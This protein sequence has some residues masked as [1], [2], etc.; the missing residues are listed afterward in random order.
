MEKMYDELRRAVLERLR[1]EAER[2]QRRDNLTVV[3][4]VSNLLPSRSIT[5][6]DQER[7]ESLVC[8]IYHEL[9]LE[10][11]IAPG[12]GN[13]SSTG[14]MEWPWYHITDHGK[15][16][17]QT[18]EYSP[19]DPDGYLRRLRSEIP[20]VE[21][22]IVRYVEESLKCLRM[23]C[24]LAAAVT[25]GC[26][27]E[28]AMLLLI[29]QFGKAIS[30]LM[31]R[32]KYEKETSFWTISSKYKTFRKNLDNVAKTLP[33]DLRDAL[34]PQLHGTFDLI[35]RIRNE[36]GH[37]TGE[38][39]TLETIR[40]SHIVFPGFCKYVYLLMDHFTRNGVNL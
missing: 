34:E 31:K 37:P 11:I 25:I 27:S 39:V 24:L 29:E 19:Y 13:L 2:S 22:T 38:P 15:R 17:L 7:I 28:K 8:Q 9:Y 3:N 1:Q 36:A 6:R 14:R 32:K 33:Q 18:R 10:R 21:E 5:E 4:Q 23:D 40:A 20:N 26:A 35:R 12:T 30:D 16:L